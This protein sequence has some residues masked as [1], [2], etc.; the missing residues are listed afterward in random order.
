MISV[1]IRG[2]SFGYKRGPQV[3]EALRLRLATSDGSPSDRGRV[4]AVMG[5]SGCGKTTLLRLLAGI[6]APAAGDVRYNP[7][8]ALISYV[9]QEPVLFEH[10]SRLEN[11]RY[12]KRVSS[13]REF[14]SEEMFGAMTEQLGLRSALESGESVLKMS[15]GERQRLSLLRALSIRPNVLLFDEPCTGLDIPVKQDFLLLLRRLTDE[16]GLLAIYVTHHP[17]EVRLVADEIVFLSKPLTGA[18][19]SVSHSGLRNFLENPPT[20]E[21]A[22]FFA[23]PAM[24]AVPC[25]FDGQLLADLATSGIIGLHVEPPPS[26]GDYLLAFTPEAMRWVDQGGAPVSCMGCSDRYRVVQMGGPDASLLVGPQTDEEPT[27]FRVE[28]PAFLFTR[29]GHYF[30]RVQI[31]S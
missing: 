14:Y 24:N 6:E 21:A 17:E 22:R 11:A 1:E 26:H 9:P 15:G 30:R 8:D 20:L 31:S 28:G 5:A 25:R 23:S 16:L 18:A 4:I 10:I 29:D 19:V 7:R 27:S 2:V 13:M 12:F 3:F